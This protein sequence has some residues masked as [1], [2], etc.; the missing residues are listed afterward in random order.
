MKFYT[1]LFRVSSSACTSREVSLDLA[2]TVDISAVNVEHKHFHHCGARLSVIW[3]IG[4]CGRIRADDYPR[5][6]TEFPVRLGI[7][8]PVSLASGFLTS[9]SWDE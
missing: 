4:K 9:P 1:P 2:F 5:D 7:F 3:G 6:R 8:P